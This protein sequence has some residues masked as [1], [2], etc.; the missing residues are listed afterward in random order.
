MNILKKINQKH[1]IEIKK[2]KK[3]KKKSYKIID[4]K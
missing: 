3:K 2:K 4:L 1:N